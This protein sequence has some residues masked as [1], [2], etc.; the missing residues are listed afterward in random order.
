MM[1]TDDEFLPTDSGNN[2]QKVDL[3][4]MQAMAD[5]NDILLPSEYNRNVVSTTQKDEDDDILVP[6][7]L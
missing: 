4:A 1:K 6:P 3:V 7:N 2:N 5:Q